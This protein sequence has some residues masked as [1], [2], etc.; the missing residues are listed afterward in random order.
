M[1][2]SMGFNKNNSTEYRPILLSRRGEWIAW[3]L[4]LLVGAT[5]IVLLLSRQPVIRAV[6]FVAIILCLSAASISLGNW[7]DRRTVI[8]IDP[9]GI[10]FT[11]RLR[12]V[13]L[14]WQAIQRL[15]VIPSRW[16]K[17]VRVIGEDSHFEFRTLGEIRVQEE[18]KGEIGFPQGEEVLRQII[19]KSGLHVVKQTKGEYYYARD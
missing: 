4:T 7:M 5:W 11:N 2:E 14:D 8:R 17:K 15:Q 6:P 9:K 18:V 1:S 16:G 13:R 19:E 10:F 12:R 3:S